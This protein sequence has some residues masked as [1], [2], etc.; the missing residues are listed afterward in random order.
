MRLYYFLV[1]VIFS[2][3]TAVPVYSQEPIYSEK[4]IHHPVVAQD[5]MVA[6]QHHLATEVGLSILKKG[7]NAYDAATGVGFALAVVLPRA[8]NLGGGGFML[9]YNEQSSKTMALNYRE[10]APAASEKDMYLDK[11]GKV[12]DRLFNQSYL[13][14]GVPGTVAG[15]TYI[16]EKY[17]KLSLKEVMLPAITLARDGFPITKD[18]SQIL[19]KYK[20]RLQKCPASAAIFYPEDGFYSKGDIL[21]QTDLANSLID[22][23]KNGSK[24]FYR[25]KL[26]KK[27]TKGI[28]KNGGI[29]SRKDFKKYKVKETTAIWG[30]YRNV[31]VASMP[32]PSSGG[33]HL[34]Q[35]LNILE[36]HNLKT[37]G[38]NSAAYLHLLIEAMRYAYADR[39]KHLGDPAFRD[40]P[41]EG[42]MSKKYAKD[43]NAKIDTHS[44]GSSEKIAPGNPIPYESN[45]TTHYSIA[46]K[47]GN[48]VSNTYTL[49]F[50]FGS[51]LMIAGTGILLNNEMGDFSAKPGSPN[52]YGLIGGEANKIE[53]FKQ[54]LSSMTPTIVFKNGKPILVTGTPG[55]S[56]IITSVLQL[57]LNVRNAMGSTQSIHIKNGWFFG[58]SD[59]RRP[60]GKTLGF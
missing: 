24:A 19:K 11:S 1:L 18:L 13:S 40:V 23:S 29:I 37:L 42:L 58:C 35:M 34:I 20:D 10:M 51:G 38:Y 5:G 45:Q 56:R 33:I 3:I 26:G 46:D 44:A 27:I 47:W 48:V 57:I 14:I 25:G 7:G 54:P 8:G 17:G 59:P 21:V 55:G 41:A 31:D 30:K 52:A 32:P 50:S 4:A 49:N 16:Q 39:S 12:D 22:I 2:L 36:H 28:S 15:M 6:T 53:A 43:I 60:D 9:H